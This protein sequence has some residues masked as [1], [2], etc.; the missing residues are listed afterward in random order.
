MEIKAPTFPESIE[1]GTL[2]AWH[3]QPGEAVRRDEMLAEIETDKVVIEIVAPRDG[4]L[5]E[6]VKAEGEMVESDEVIAR[7][8]PGAVAD[9]PPAASTGEPV[10]EPI[11]APAAVEVGISPAA[12]KLAEEEG[13]DIATLTVSDGCIRPYVWIATAGVHIP[14][15]SPQA[16]QLSAAGLDMPRKVLDLP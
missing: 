1:D 6:I 16:R 11:S 2:A 10:G 13:I 8:E 9:A 7:F 15:N 14:P 12:R 5:T 3:R 4:A